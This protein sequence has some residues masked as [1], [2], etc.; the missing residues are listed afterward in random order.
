MLGHRRKS[1]AVAVAALLLPAL[2]PAAFAEAS[3][4]DLIAASIVRI[5]AE[6]GTVTLRH[7]PIAHLHLPGGTTVF[8]YVDSRIIIGR[9]DGDSVFFRADRVD[10]TLTVTMII[11]AATPR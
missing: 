5:D 9:R 8:R 3:A 11:P 2:A 4:R 10:M 7:A 1:I 6:R